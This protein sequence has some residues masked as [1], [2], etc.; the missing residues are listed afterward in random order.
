VWL[1]ATVLRTA[2]PSAPPIC[3]ETFVIPDASPASA[4]G[5]SAIASV[6]SG[7]NAMPIPSPI[8]KQARKTVGK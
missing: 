8:A 2:S 5:T 4:A 1:A 7:M 6:S 3:W